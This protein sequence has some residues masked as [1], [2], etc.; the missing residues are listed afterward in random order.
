MYIRYNHFNQVNFMILAQFESF[1]LSAIPKYTY[2]KNSS[3]P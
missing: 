3:S 1:S 2:F